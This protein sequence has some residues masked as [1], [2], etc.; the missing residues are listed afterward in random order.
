MDGQTYTIEK[1]IRPLFADPVT[2]NKYSICSILQKIFCLH[3]PESYSC[4]TAAKT[5]TTWHTPVLR[6]GTQSTELSYAQAM[7]CMHS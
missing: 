2:N 5:V 7:H 6:I 3:L 4:P 1:A